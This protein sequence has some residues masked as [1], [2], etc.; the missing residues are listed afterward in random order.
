MKKKG[1]HYTDKYLLNRR[2]YVE[3]Y[4][5]PEFGDCRPESIQ[6]REIDDWLLS[7][8]K[9]NGNEPAGETKNKSEL[10]GE[11]KN[12]ILYTLSLIFEEL[13]DLEIIETNPV[14]GIKPYDKAP[15]NPRGT[16]D[17]EA[18]GKLYPETHGKLVQVWG[19][20]M[21]AAMMLVFNDT[22]SRPG[23]VRA[24]TWADI[25]VHKRFIPIRKGIQSGTPDSVKETKTGAVKAGF[26]SVR[27]IQE[28]DIWRAES[29]HS[30]NGDYVFSLDGETPVTNEAVIK[31]FRRGLVRVEIDQPK[32][33][34]YWLRH[35]F[36]TY[37]MENL[38]D[39][40]IS[41]LMGNGVAVLRKHYQHPDD[42]TLYRQ[43][44][45]IQEKLDKA[46]GG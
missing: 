11:T 31:A 27:T 46:R 3:N 35:S 17:R 44:R 23:E 21:W 5:I 42:E 41:L 8:K 36:G 20:S 33:T 34:P 1:H 18:L 40:E 39:G 45:A 43:T 4:I 25:D 7:L 24:L 19:S 37:Q 26:L 14:V 30:Q 6:R 22:G 12:K 32:W 15:V 10:A 16:I 2:G 9:K 13:R 38:S 28:L 29:R